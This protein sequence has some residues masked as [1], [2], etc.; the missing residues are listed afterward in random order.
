MAA[1]AEELDD[2]N[3]KSEVARYQWRGGRDYEH[4]LHGVW[5]VMHKLQRS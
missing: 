4:A 1:Q 3:F 2:D 5:E